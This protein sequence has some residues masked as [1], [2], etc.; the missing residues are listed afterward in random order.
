MVVKPGITE[1]YSAPA[2][3]KRI[4]CLLAITPAEGETLLDVGAGNGY[5]S[6]L[7]T[8]KCRTVTALDL[9]RPECDYENVMPV[10]GDVTQLQFPDNSFDTVVCTQVLEH[11]PTRLLS[12]ACTEIARVAK[13]NVVI[14]VPY[15][16]DLRLERV[17]CP[18]C[19]RDNPPWAH[20]NTFDERKLLRLFPLLNE[21]RKV[22]VGERTEWTN[23]FAVRLMDLGGNPWGLY[24][25][26]YPWVIGPER[27]RCRDCGSIL[28]RP[29]ERSVAQRAICKLAVLVNVMQSRVVGSAPNWLYV[30]FSKPRLSA[31]PDGTDQES[32]QRERPHSGCQ[33]R[34]ANDGRSGS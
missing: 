24:T 3:Q 34:K 16:Q 20:V 31:V 9:V 6:H 29:P 23:G 2:V 17:T 27:G 21:L 8:E 18:V 22:Y 10:Q 4:A 26:Q 33:T 1:Y 7:L 15:R 13:Y 19:R 32:A 5:I 30:A 12:K 14:G 11:V 25:E 28:N